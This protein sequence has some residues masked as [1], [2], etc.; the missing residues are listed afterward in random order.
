M[1]RRSRDPVVAQ[2]AYDNT[3]STNYDSPG[4]TEVTQNVPVMATPATGVPVAGVAG[5]PVA[6]APAQ[7]NAGLYEEPTYNEPVNPGAG[8]TVGL[9]G[10]LILV[11]G[12][13]AGIV[14][15]IGPIFGYAATFTGS[16]VWDTRHVYLWLIP[17]AVAAFLGLVLMLRSPLVSAGL[18]RSLELFAGLVVACCGAWLVIGPIAW[19]GI[20]GA[21]AFNPASPWRMFV[22]EVGYSFG[23]GAILVLL[24]GT[25]MGAV[26]V[27]ERASA[28]SGAYGANT[29]ARSDRRVAA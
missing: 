19:R 23:P 1:L 17:G 26:M 14:A 6:A 27:A 20:G 11:F 3:G 29:V 7:S 13:W 18:S 2:P 15:F 10:F 16:W 21:V 9:A 24:G 28:R 25:V 5:V 4:S 22:N 8:H 12:A